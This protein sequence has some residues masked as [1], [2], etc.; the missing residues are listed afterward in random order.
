MYSCKVPVRAASNTCRG[1]PRHSRPETTVFVSA[2]TRT[3]GSSL[4][5]RCLDF[6]FDF[7]L[8]E[9]REGSQT[10][11]GIKQLANAPALHFL[12]Q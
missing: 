8:G 2:T 11:R 1:F 10:I 5:A 7:G 6:C 12:S 4:S 9:R 3:G